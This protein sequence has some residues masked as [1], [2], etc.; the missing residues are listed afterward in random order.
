MISDCRNAAKKNPE[1]IEK[2]KIERKN[3]EEIISSEHLI[4]FGNIFQMKNSDNDG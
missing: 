3:G 2:K 1:K 4:F